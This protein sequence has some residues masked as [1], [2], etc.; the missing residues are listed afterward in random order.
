MIKGFLYCYIVETSKPWKD[1]EKHLY[2]LSNGGIRG[3]YSERNIR[4]GIIVT[5][6]PHS[7]EMSK[8]E[9]DLLQDETLRNKCSGY[10]LERTVEK[11]KSKPPGKYV[12]LPDED[13]KP[14]PFGHLLNHCRKHPNLK[15]SYQNFHSIGY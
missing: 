11:R 4:S 9:W 14:P 12:F 3:V 8:R 6:Y 5:I 7:E 10:I 15:V 1:V 2:L 13:T